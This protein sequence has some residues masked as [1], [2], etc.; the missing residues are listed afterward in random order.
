MLCRYEDAVA[1]E[2]FHV[3]GGVECAQKFV[4]EAD[5]QLYNALV[6]LYI[7]D[8]L[9][10]I[11]SWSPLCYLAVRTRCDDDIPLTLY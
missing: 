3:I 7:P 6:D 1:V 10:P 2:L 8:V 11:P 9:R 5:Y 4:R